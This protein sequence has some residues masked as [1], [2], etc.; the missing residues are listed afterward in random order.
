MGQGQSNNHGGTQQQQQQE[1]KTSYYDL[2]TLD[3]H[4]TEEE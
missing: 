3:R 1:L 4:A 2:L